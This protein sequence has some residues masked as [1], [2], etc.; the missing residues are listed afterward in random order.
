MSKTIIGVSKDLKIKELTI[1]ESPN[2]TYSH[3][4]WCY[5]EVRWDSTFDLV[6]DN[7]EN[8]FILPGMSKEVYSWLEA[9]EQMKVE[10]INILDLEQ[11]EVD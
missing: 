7:D 11:V 2:E 9:I 10:G 5:G 1:E 6:F 8:D 4:I 3:E